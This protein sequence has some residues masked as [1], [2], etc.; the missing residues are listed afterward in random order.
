MAFRH[1]LAERG[2]ET[3]AED[4]MKLLPLHRASGASKSPLQPRATLQLLLSLKEDS[5]DSSNSSNSSIAAA[6]VTPAAAAAATAAAA[7]ATAAAAA[8][9]AAAAIRA[10][11]I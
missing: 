1:T 6:A 11:T 5:K 7:A 9:I 8:A 10:E 2:S 3:R 4:N